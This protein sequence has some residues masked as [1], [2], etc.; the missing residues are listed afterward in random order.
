MTESARN[1]TIEKTA[2]LN[3]KDMMRKEIGWA[4][5]G[6]LGAFAALAYPPPVIE[7][8]G[9]AL[10]IDGLDQGP[11][12]AVADWDRRKINVKEF[13]T[14]N[15]LPL[16]FTLSNGTAKAVSGTLSVWM[17]EDWTVSGGDETVTVASGEVRTLR[18]VAKAK[19]SVLPALYPVHAKFTAEGTE[20]H[21]IAVFRAKTPNRA[22]KREPRFRERIEEGRWRLDNGFRMS[23]ALHVKGR[24]WALEGKNG[25]D[26]V[27]HGVFH[28]TPGDGFAAGVPAKRGFF[29]HPPYVTGT[30][31][32][33]ADFPIELPPTKDGVR[34]R[35]FNA[36]S[37]AGKARNPGDGVTMRVQVKGDGESDF[38]EIFSQNVPTSGVWQSG[39]VDLSSHAGKKLVLRLVTDPGPKG[40]TS[41]D[42]CAWGDPV[43]EVGHMPPASD[44]KS[45]QARE[46][47]AAQ[48]A[49]QALDAGADP[50][51]GV[52]RLEDGGRAF[53]AG[54]EY[55]PYGILD[56]AIAFTDGRKVLTIRGF[57]VEL[58]GERLTDLRSAPVVGVR[59]FAEKGA[60]R[61]A[62]DTAKAQKAADGSPRFTR[63]APGPASHAA[64]RVY[65]GTGCVWEGLEKL[66]FRGSGF[67]LSTRHVGMDY[68]NGLSLVE[69]VDFPADFLEVDSSNRLARLVT[70]N[71]AVFSFVPSDRGAFDAAVR[72]AHVSGYRA[73]PGIPA[74]RNR[75][76]IDDWSGGNTHRGYLVQAEALRQA[77]KYGLD[78]V[79]Y[80]QHNW[81]RWGYDAR[82][83]EVYPP[84]GDKAEFDEMVR[85]A[86]ESGYLFGIHD[87]YVDY[88]PDA[89]GFSYKLFCYNEDGTPLEAWYNP[90]PRSL[91]YR[92]L[93][94]AIHPRLKANMAL[95]R[96]GFRP[97][98]LFL[99]VF[100]ASGAKD[101]IDHTGRFHPHA[102]NLREW[103]RAWEECREVYG[104]PD[105][106]TVS[107]A[108]S[109]SQI[110]S[111]D[112]GEADH[113]D[114][115]YQAWN[116]TFDDGERVP[117]H[118]AVTH[119][120]MLLFGGGL[121]SRYCR[122]TP[123]AR[124]D[125]DTELH[126]YGTDDY[127]STTVIGG[128]VPMGPSFGRITAKTYWMLHDVCGSLGQAAFESLSFEDDNLHRLH[129]RFSNGGEVWAN[130]ATNA[131]WRLADGRTLPT[132]GWYAKTGDAESCVEL[133]DGVRVGWARHPGWWFVDAR[134]VGVDDGTV[135]T[136]AS[137]ALAA[138]IGADNV[139]RITTEW[140]VF[141]PIA[142]VYRPFTHVVSTKGKAI[143]FHG[144]GVALTSEARTTPGRHEGIVCVPVPKDAPAGDYAVLYGFFNP[145]GNRLPIRGLCDDNHRVWG[146]IIRIERPSDGPMRLSWRTGGET[147]RDRE[148]GLNVEGKVVDFGGIRT[149]GAFRLETGT[150]DWTLT[151][152]PGSGPFHA[153][154]DLSKCGASGRKVSA[155]ETVDSPP[156]AMPPTFGQKGDRLTLSCDAAAFAY[157]IKFG[158]FG[159]SSL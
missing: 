156:Y 103:C 129:T 119:G 8:G 75:I 118:D 41:C 142:A 36:L 54:V 2:F 120:K 137:K 19:P 17:N 146:G 78:D 35:F 99:D 159:L 52:Y 143:S 134:P 25:V 39:E 63:L 57:E 110:G 12:P 13:D 72:F 4:L 62:W 106:V 31:E 102:E 83:P 20:L 101:V 148:L 87:N 124:E 151:P 139:V 96:D 81:Q 49:K 22:F 158:D 53:G 34:F 38:R 141:K 92:W 44:E 14:A 65:A 84:R 115:K 40:N 48:K 123:G 105:A 11:K 82:L 1:D 47:A 133:R 69:A 30:G 94:Q 18:R 77:K 150:A 125:G 3:T 140:N 56:A 149:D 98:A 32:V 43:I 50:A 95:Q 23:V 127:L 71:D 55:G 64:K 131:V 116:S 37:N 136:V 138:E 132:Y 61:V 51:Q 15:D 100:T 74:M 76:C 128:R 107:E 147:V 153:E 93:P 26:T 109:D 117:W 111:I 21:P 97:T 58:D 114:P 108:G 155:V 88:Y 27:S 121:G 130:R 157:R 46:A 79:L 24:S 90:G 60:L 113:F 152:L 59:V 135:K 126:G 68:G 80:L 144:H 45:W 67:S 66:I 5:I 89:E 7:Q 145:T 9:V 42:S 85:A 91:S 154:I 122:V 86:R 104:V 10:T 29:A 73:S 6:G 28:R 33:T 16:S 112:A 70:H